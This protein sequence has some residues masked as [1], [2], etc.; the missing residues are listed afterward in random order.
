MPASEI[1]NFYGFVHQLVG[2]QVHTLTGVLLELAVLVDFGRLLTFDELHVLLVAEIVPAYRVE[3]LLL[4]LL[5]V[6]LFVGL[7]VA[8]DVAGG[9]LQSG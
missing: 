2:D 1:V 5:L 6:L 7:P 8:G 9:F 4:F 3:L